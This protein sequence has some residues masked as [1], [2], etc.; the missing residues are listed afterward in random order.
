MDI[1]QLDQYLLLIEVLA[2]EEKGRE[3][4]QAVT[5]LINTLLET[6]K[7]QM[8]DPRLLFNLFDPLRNSASRNSR[9]AKVSFLFFVFRRNNR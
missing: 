7:T 2:A 8:A 1:T 4:F 9:I 3:E 5:K 6:R